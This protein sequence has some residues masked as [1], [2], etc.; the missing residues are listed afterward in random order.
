MRLYDTLSGEKRD[1]TPRSDEITMYV[2]GPNL[3]GP[4]HIGHALSYLFFDVLRRYLEYRA[5]VCA[6][7]RTSRT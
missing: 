5:T 3:Y 1:F 2:C 4:C 7:S 6:R